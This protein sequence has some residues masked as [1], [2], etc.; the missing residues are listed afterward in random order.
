VKKHF[1][2]VFLAITIAGSL[3]G[4]AG[5]QTPPP[6]SFQPVQL[7][8]KAYSKQF[9]TFIVVLDTASSM[10][11]RY[12]KRLEADRAQEIASR[13]NR[14]VPLLDYRA[15]LLAFDSGSCL[16]CD[17]AVVLYG[18]ALYNREEFAAGLAGY[19]TTERAKR[20]I[21]TDSASRYILRGN[22]GRIAV[23]VLSG[24]ENILHGR[25]YKT[26]QKLRGSL[27][28]RLCLYPV[29]MDPDR[30]ASIVTD[31]IVEVAGCGFAVAADDIAEPDAMAR[32]V[33]E[34]FLGR[35]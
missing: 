12:R 13:L 35:P 9:D 23:I 5:K 31:L 32:Y 22:P 24:S 21:S 25:T 17:D 7:G 19:L 8:P 11:T 4:C 28:D 3:A 34:V 27:G 10:D 15:E 29:L 6:E 30:D 14:T 1:W 18:P 33:E 20:L 16:S 2:L 26:V